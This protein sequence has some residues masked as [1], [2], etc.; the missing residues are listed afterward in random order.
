MKCVA[1]ISNLMSDTNA[2]AYL[3]PRVSLSDFF[4]GGPPMPPPPAPPAHVFDGGAR[5]GLIPMTWGGMGGL[6][7][8]TWGGMGGPQIILF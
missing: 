1:H 4:G 6:G 8:Q 2:M 3:L 7:H 5:G